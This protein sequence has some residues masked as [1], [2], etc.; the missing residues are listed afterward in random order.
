[1]S[2]GWT[3]ER[4]RRQAEA[5]RRHKPWEKSTGPKTLRGKQSSSLNAL[6]HGLRSKSASELKEVLRINRDFVKH[7]QL[8]CMLMIRQGVHAS[9]LIKNAEKSMGT[10]RGVSKIEQMD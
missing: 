1:M 2:K 9:K 6:K 5:I 8:F 7:Y 4:R 3:E 10:P